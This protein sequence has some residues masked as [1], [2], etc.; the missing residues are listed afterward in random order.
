[1]MSLT[2]TVREHGEGVWSVCPVGSLDGKTSS[3][4][5]NE[6]GAL[7]GGGARIITFDLKDLSYLSTAGLEVIFATMKALEDRGGQ[8]VLTN[9]QP[10]IRKVFDIIYS[11]PTLSIFRSVEELDRYLDHM[12]R[13]APRGP[14]EHGGLFKP[15]SAAL[16]A[17]ITALPRR[18]AAAIEESWPGVRLL[19]VDGEAGSRPTVRRA[20]QREGYLVDVAATGAEGLARL[21]QTA[22]D[23]VIT[24]R[25]LP[26]MTGLELI[27][28]VQSMVRAAPPTIV[29]TALGDWGTYAQALELGVVAF[30][31]KP[32]RI[33]ELSQ[34]VVRA[35]SARGSSRVRSFPA[36]K[37]AA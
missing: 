32:V 27:T 31:S 14:L 26:D 12:Q 34:Q 21:R 19:L 36:R 2:V 8:V 18:A 5:R 33:S 15:A 35:L 22:Y 11:A 13:G 1:M 23:L 16:L 30:L 3:I 28:V 24:E 25:Y 9:L 17:G 10:Q 29:L 7:R 4:L 37:L 6:I 20:L